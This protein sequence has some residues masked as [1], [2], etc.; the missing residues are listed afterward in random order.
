M[1]VNTCGFNLNQVLD[2]IFS[3]EKKRKKFRHLGFVDPNFATKV[4]IS[5][6]L[7]LLLFF[8]FFFHSFGDVG[9]GGIHVEMTFL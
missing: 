2:L 1:K 9:E 8:F 7:L 3:G 4:E 6:L 5:L